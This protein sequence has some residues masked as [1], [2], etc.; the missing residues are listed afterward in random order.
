MTPDTEFKPPCL[1]CGYELVGIPADQNCPECGMP[2]SITL[3]HKTRLTPHLHRTIRRSARAAIYA[4]ARV[5]L[6][7]LA[8]GLSLLMS[9]QAGVVPSAPRGTLEGFLALATLATAA[10]CW[11]LTTP[12]P[13][14]EGARQ[15]AFDAQ[16][17]RIALRAALLAA[18]VVIA[19]GVVITNYVVPPG[20]HAVTFRLVYSNLL[21]LAIAVA[22]LSL[23]AYIRW[24]ALAVP[25]RA[26][27]V[28]ASAAFWQGCIAI[29]LAAAAGM[30]WLLTPRTNAPGLGQ[31]GMLTV[32]VAV[33]TPIIPIY[34][35]STACSMLVAL[36]NRLKA[37]NP[38]PLAPAEP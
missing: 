16:R 10:S 11:S 14:M 2:A 3:E 36:I 23:I 17:L 9:G 5:P 26:L 25:S 19:L 7:L 34:L 18:S 33:A 30:T 38:A 31:V 6:A 29:A 4:I 27:R 1:A 35:L 21:G 12:I 28:R 13:A 20:T 8:A 15:G 22:Y 24:L 32:F 37:V